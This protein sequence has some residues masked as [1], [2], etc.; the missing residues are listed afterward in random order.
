MGGY[1]IVP[2]PSCWDFPFLNDA[3]DETSIVVREICNVN[4]GPFLSSMSQKCIQ[5]RGY[6]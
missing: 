6:R 3:L 2:A 1:K 4:R 5:Q